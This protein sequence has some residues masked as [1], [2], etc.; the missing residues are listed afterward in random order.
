MAA[1]GSGRLA[2]GARTCPGELRAPRSECGSQF[3]GGREAGANQRDRRCQ[4]ISKPPERERW[5]GRGRSGIA[6]VRRR[7]DPELEQRDEV[8]A[9]RDVPEAMRRRR[10]RDRTKAAFEIPSQIP[11]RPDRNASPPI[12][13]TI[14]SRDV[15]KTTISRLSQAAIM[16]AMSA[17]AM[18]DVPRTL[19]LMPRR[20]WRPCLASSGTPRGTKAVPCIVTIGAGPDRRLAGDGTRPSR[21]G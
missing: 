8:R 17:A 21:K 12:V 7:H 14:S 6:R 15:G 13:K 5:G 19:R 20:A 18:T 11:A 1:C 3:E 10:K 4:P 16:R 9:G 2:A